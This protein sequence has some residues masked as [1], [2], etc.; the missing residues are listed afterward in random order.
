MLQ[1][2]PGN[3]LTEMYNPTIT[4]MDPIK[5]RHQNQTQSVTYFII[6]CGELTSGSLWKHSPSNMKRLVQDRNVNHGSHYLN[7]RAE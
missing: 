2:L 3:T 7:K 6:Q 1:F 4:K 5:L